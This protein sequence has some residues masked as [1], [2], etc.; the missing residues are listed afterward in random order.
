MMELE[1]HAMVVLEHGERV[2]MNKL[3]CQEIYTW[4]L[5]NGDFEKHSERGH[6]PGRLWS[7]SWDVHLQAAPTS[8]CERS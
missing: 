2:A 6:H 7:L 4:Q 3:D 1:T 8:D 5:L